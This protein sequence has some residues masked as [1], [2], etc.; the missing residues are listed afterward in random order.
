MTAVDAKGATVELAD[1]VEGYLRASEASRDRVEDATLVLSVGDDVEAKFT[2][3]DRKNRAINLSGF[4]RKTKLMRKMQSQL[5]TN[6][7]MQTSPTTQWLKLS[8]QL[9]ASNLSLS[10]YNNLNYDEFT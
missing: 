10:G 5:L 6:R 1:G 3:V 8:K 4:V 7:K 2:G 9:K